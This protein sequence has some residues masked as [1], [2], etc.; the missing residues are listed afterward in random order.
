MAKSLQHYG[1][2]GMH[3]GVRSAA[4]GSSGEKRNQTLAD[5]KKVKSAGGEKRLQ[6]SEKLFENKI[7][8]ILKESEKK[9]SEINSSSAPRAI[10]FLQKLKLDHDDGGQIIKAVTDT[11]KVYSD[12]EKAFSKERK[13]KLKEAENT[14]FDKYQK[15]ADKIFTEKIDKMPFPASLIESIKLDKDLDS[16]MIQELL[17]AELAIEKKVNR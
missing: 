6:D 15:M 11:D 9:V 2:I 14:I 1:V 5:I 4:K 17:D 16:K 13:A 10:K 3:W 12:R 7:N 8:S